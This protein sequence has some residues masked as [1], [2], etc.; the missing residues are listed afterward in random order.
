MGYNEDREFTDYIHD[1][2][3]IPLIYSPLNWKVQKI[4]SQRLTEN[5]DIFTAIDAFLINITK[6]RIITVQERFRECKY[7]KYNDF[8]IRYK[9]DFN[10]HEERK[11]SEFF[12][13]DADYFVYGIV[14]TYK[15]QKEKATKFL[16]YAV[17][18]IKILK[19]LFDTNQIIIDESI[20]GLFCVLKNNKIYCPVN[21]NRDNS[22]SFIPIDIRL[23]K[24]L[25]GNSG[26]ILQ[27]EGF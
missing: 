27:S 8:T 22:S 18:D 1:N 9:R 13:L 21:F 6:E 15:Y 20:K 4:S 16:K 12:K 24:K 14:D 2:L 7:A 23:L 26:V 11:L 25:F 10:K 5:A 19:S 17:I 3:A